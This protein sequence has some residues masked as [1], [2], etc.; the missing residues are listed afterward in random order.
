MAHGSELEGGKR[1][2]PIL[3]VD[4]RGHGLA[5]YGSIERHTFARARSYTHPHPRRPRPIAIGRANSPSPLLLYR[6][7]RTRSP[8]PGTSRSRRSNARHFR[9][10]GDQ[11]RQ[12]FP[13]C[14]PFGIAQAW[15]R[16]SGRRVSRKKR[17]RCASPVK[18]DVEPSPRRFRAPRFARHRRRRRKTPHNAWAAGRGA[19]NPLVVHATLNARARLCGV[20]PR[21]L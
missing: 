3:G 17:A 9:D 18:D 13:E 7:K 1:R 21:R 6:P 20:T 10:D 4:A 19:L 12:R 5:H 8:S 16:A 11:S 15:L 2:W 14:A